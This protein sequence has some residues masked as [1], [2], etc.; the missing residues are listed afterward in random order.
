MRRLNEGGRKVTTEEVIGP[1]RLCLRNRPPNC[2]LYCHRSAEGER[3]YSATGH[4]IFAQ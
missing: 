4:I 1:V 3:S 2:N